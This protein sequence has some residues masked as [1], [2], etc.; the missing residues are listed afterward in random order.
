M[1]SQARLMRESPVA[2]EALARF[3]QTRTVLARQVASERSLIETESRET[4]Q[5]VRSVDPKVIANRRANT[6]ARQEKLDTILL[7]DTTA[8][9]AFNQTLTASVNTASA[10]AIMAEEKAQRCSILPS[11][12]Y[13][14]NVDDSS[15]D[16]TPQVLARMRAR[17]PG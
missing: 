7:Q 5:L 9:E 11:R 1:L 3:R 6:A 17:P 16:I 4:D 10:P 14:L 12:E 8:L 15:L 2:L 13:V